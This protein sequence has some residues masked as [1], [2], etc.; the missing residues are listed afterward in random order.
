[1]IAKKKKP[2]Q[3]V[4]KVKNF[5]GFRLDEEQLK[6]LDLIAEQAKKSRGNIAK[7]AIKEWL[8]YQSFLSTNKM[9]FIS[10]KM[11]TSLL[12]LANKEV[13]VS[14]AENMGDLIGNL[15]KYTIAK[16]VNLENLNEYLQLLSNIFLFSGGLMWFSTFDYQFKEDKVTIRGLHDLGEK[17][18]QFFI[19]FFKYLMTNHL[20]CV[21]IDTTKEI[22]SQ[23]IFLEF[24]IQNE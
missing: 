14:I 12:S 15:I 8:D 24:E 6:Q 2:P 11:F 1:M 16:P 21:L 17:F 23:L 7:E 18:S 4:K 3:K 13:F 10:R 22:T 19:K 20:N 5:I 9:V